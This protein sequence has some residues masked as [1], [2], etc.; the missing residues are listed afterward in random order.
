ML[1]RTTLV[2]LTLIQAAGCSSGAGAIGPTGATGA[3]G[4]AGSPDTAQQ[5]L[6][7]LETLDTAAGGLDAGLLAGQ[8]ASAY[9]L[10]GARSI[11]L[12][13][14]T[15]HVTAGLAYWDNGLVFPYAG[16]YAVWSFTLG[17]DYVPNSP[18][19]VTALVAVANNSGVP[20]VASIEGNRYYQGRDGQAINSGS[21][22]AIVAISNTIALPASTTEK[23]VVMT[24]SI[25][26]HSPFTDIQPGD[27]FTFKLSR[28][29]VSAS[30]DTCSA[31]NDILM[32]L[33]INYTGR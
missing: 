29:N 14:Y 28:R 4:P 31:N 3:T 22:D 7:K 12:S 13:P 20:C 17:P 30:S 24:Y 11:S 8:P 2:F 6:D 1:K 32:G 26:P 27:S 5:I 9:A 21:G 16:G 33:R 19:T 25:P 23:T 18:L 15:P 10:S